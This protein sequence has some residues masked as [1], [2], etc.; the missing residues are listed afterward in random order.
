MNAQEFQSS[1]A[2]RE[3]PPVLLIHGDEDFLVDECVQAVLSRTLDE[4]TKGF[5]LD[6]VY[7]TKVDVKE[8]I[9]L[10]SAFPMMAPRRVVVVREFE[11]LAGTDPAK[12]QFASYLQNPL[13]STCLVLVSLQPD[14][15]KK[16][17][18]DLKKR[19]E[20]VECKSLFDNQVPDWIS[21]R[22]QTL[23]KSAD[24]QATRLLQAYVG[25]SLRALQN[26]ID[27]LFIYVG[28]KKEISAE[29]VTAVVGA[30]KGY[31]VFELQNAIG[32][33]DLREA[34]TILQAM[35][36][37]GQSPQ[38]IIVMLTR[39]FNQ[40][41]KLGELRSKGTP[42]GEIAK[43]VGIH[44]FFLKQLIQFHS[45]FSRDH[46]ENGYR[47]LLEADTVLK[48]TSRDPRVVMDIMVY[49]LVR[50]VKEREH[51]MADA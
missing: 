26:E 51:A 46:I 23:G 19:A 33:K 11:K 16:P 39:F 18:T 42:D 48:S 22:V 17:F 37:A 20:L 15:R 14:F 6:V 40:L 35:L 13:A 38:M 3:L 4:G 31:T 41:W 34:L 25:N 2:G 50:G 28:D 49:T 21:R 24:P 7:G 43:E 44:P 45:G 12:E 29:D 1:V 47:T 30:S 10:A 32:R 9:A 5:N 8:V 36:Q 27:K